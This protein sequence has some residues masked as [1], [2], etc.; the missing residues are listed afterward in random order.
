MKKIIITIMAII[1]VL[2]FSACGTIP[3][4]ETGVKIID[5]IVQDEVLEAGRYA[6][7]GP[8]TRIV[9]VNNKR[10]TYT[11]KN[12]IWGES[13]EQVV[14]YA[15]DVS[16]TYQITKEASVWLVKNMGDDLECILPSAKIASAI[17]NA[18]ANID[19][20]KCTNRSYIEPAAKME[21][22]TMMDEYYYVGAV[23]VIDVSI[24]QM[25][26]EDSYNEQI[27]KISALRKQAEADAITNQMKI[28]TAKAEAEAET[29]KAEAAKKTAEA[30]AEIA[31][32][33]AQNAAEVA[34]IEAESYAEVHTIQAD[35]DV[36]RM[37][38]I[39]E[40]LTPE[41]IDYIRA[42]NWNGELPDTIVSDSASVILDITG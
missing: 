14:V 40:A 32:I 24:G 38:K 41:Y 42:N 20:Q 6:N 31:L 12:K 34:R 36:T 25:D 1:C 23:E 7:P 2:L 10:Q 29:T 26:Y 5:G 9:K 4:G 37:E 8:R 18:L 22:Q 28:D 11:Y 16:I 17:K 15:Q 39:I 27:A 3:S 13:N 21:V 33:E 30:N 19:T 35:A